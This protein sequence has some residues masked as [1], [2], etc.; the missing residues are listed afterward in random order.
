MI[1]SLVKQW[2]QEKIAY[3]WVHARESYVDTLIFLILVSLI[4]W[5]EKEDV[6]WGVLISNTFLIYLRQ[7]LQKVVFSLVWITISLRVRNGLGFRENVI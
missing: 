4:R 7:G 2:K 6:F 1:N 3:T 5:E